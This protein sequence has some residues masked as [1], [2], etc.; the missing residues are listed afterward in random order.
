MLLTG[1]FD[2]GKKL[3]INVML[4]SY[5]G[6]VSSFNVKGER[7]LRE[8]LKSTSRIRRGVT[9]RRAIHVRNRCIRPGLLKNRELGRGGAR[10]GREIKADAESREVLELREKLKDGH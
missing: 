6:N 1:S 3:R 4:S 2:T 10:W 5:L 9:L 7:A 8:T